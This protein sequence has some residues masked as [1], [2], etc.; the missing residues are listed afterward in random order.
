MARKAT[1]STSIQKNNNNYMQTKISKKIIK[2]LKKK[3]K[4]K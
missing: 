2:F 3:K 1:I 4:T